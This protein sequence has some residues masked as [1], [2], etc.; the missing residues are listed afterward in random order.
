MGYGFFKRDTNGSVRHWHWQ[1]VAPSSVQI[2]R[3]PSAHVEAKRVYRFNPSEFRESRLQV[4]ETKRTFMPH[5]RCRR[6]MSSGSAPPPPQPPGGSMLM[7]LGVMVIV[8]V[9][10]QLLY[11][12]VYLHQQG[13]TLINGTIL[14]SKLHKL[15]LDF[16]TVLIFVL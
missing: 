10:F 9:L 7:M 12:V 15:Q 5:V 14:W 4:K 1:R 2:E 13:L 16:V 6:I 11:K 3:F 8:M